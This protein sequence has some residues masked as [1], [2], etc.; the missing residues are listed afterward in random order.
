M[1]GEKSNDDAGSELTIH[2]CNSWYERHQRFRWIKSEQSSH[3][4][5][6][7]V[8]DECN[9]WVDRYQRFQKMKNESSHVNKSI[10][11]KM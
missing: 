8:I 7:N 2:E 10:I 5:L 1:K 9:H 11:S 4:N 6:S 3:P